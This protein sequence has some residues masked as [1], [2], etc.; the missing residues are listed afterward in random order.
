MMN[1][2]DFA[3]TSKPG[4]EFDA[5]WSN[6]FHELD[7]KTIVAD[8]KRYR[9]IQVLRWWFSPFSECYTVECTSYDD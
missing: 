2:Y 6:E 5:C 7:R 4:T 9:R 8:E 1:L 3:E